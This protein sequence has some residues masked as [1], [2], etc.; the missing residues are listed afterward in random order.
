MKSPKELS[1]LLIFARVADKGSFTLAAEALGMTKSA[2]SQQVALLESRIGQQ[3][4][5]RT[6]RGL[7]LTALGERLHK[8]SRML[9]DQVALIIDDIHT[10][11]TAPKGR[12]SIGY[13]HSIE[14]SAVLPAVTQLGVEFPA[15]E[16]VLEANDR[17]VDLVEHQL[18]VAI[19]FGELK[20][21]SYRALPLGQV[22]EIFAASPLYISKHGAINALADLE[23]HRWITTPWQ[24]KKVNLTTCFDEQVSFSV[25]PKPYVRST[26]FPAVKEL[27][28]RDMGFALLP[29]VIVQPYIEAGE[30]VHILPEFEGPT[31]P[32]YLL[33]AF[34]SN[35]PMH[36]IR[37]HQLLQQY[38]A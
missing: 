28:L 30:L 36:V 19:R 33:H 25:L 11:Q 17:S 15:L 13:P 3:L 31:W 34:Q 21:S 32:V 16:L 24:N 1:R 8:R 12:F 27:V 29:D 10:A 38:L 6:T 23:R 22:K 26:T 4:L 18:D 5:H 20:D 7:S 37:L 2:V 9:Q 35:R 14:L